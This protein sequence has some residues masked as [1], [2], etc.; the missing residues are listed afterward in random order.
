MDFCFLL[1]LQMP[2]KPINGQ[3]NGLHAAYGIDLK[4]GYAGKK[5]IFGQAFVF[6]Q[7]VDQ[8]TVFF[9]IHQFFFLGLIKDKSIAKYKLLAGIT[10]FEVYTIGR[11]KAIKLAID[12]FDRHLKK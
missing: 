7:A 12:W 3:L 2:I 10:H 9:N 6:Y 5:L 4:M 1:F 11:M 8:L